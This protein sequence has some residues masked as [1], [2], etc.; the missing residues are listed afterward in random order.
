MNE[1]ADRGIGLPVGPA[2]RRGRAAGARRGAVRPGPRRRLPGP[3]DRRVRR[4]GAGRRACRRRR[5]PAAA[6]RSTQGS[7]RRPAPA[8]WPATSRAASARAVDGAGRVPRRRDG[9][10]AGR[11]ERRRLPDRPAD[12]RAARAPLLLPPTVSPGPP[13]PDDAARAGVA[14]GHRPGR[15]GRMHLRG[16]YRPRG[17]SRRPGT[18]RQ[19]HP[20]GGRHRRDADQGAVHEMAA[21][22]QNGMASALNPVHTMFDGDIVFGVSTGRAAPPDPLGF[23]S[24][25]RGGGRCG[26]P[27]DRP[28][29]AGRTVTSTPAGR[30]PS[31]RTAGGDLTIGSD[32]AASVG[33]P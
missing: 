24:D 14:D 15:A 13:V 11:G 16:R 25:H 23:P 31:W 8:R 21:V 20:G 29:A 33:A 17:R 10:G 5:R 27:G 6:D 26:H 4:A 9:R 19:H 28:G 2:P 12:R 30:W 22:A 3:A 18:I 1:L 7:R 32:R